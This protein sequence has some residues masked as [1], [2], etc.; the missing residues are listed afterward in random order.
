MDGDVASLHLQHL[1]AAPSV[2]LGSGAGY[3]SGL[4]SQLLHTAPSA[5]LGTV[6]GCLVAIHVASSVQPRS[7]S[8]LVCAAP[9]LQLGSAADYVSG[10][11]S[12]LLHTTYSNL[13]TSINMYTP[14]DHM[15]E[16]VYIF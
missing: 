13:P 10:L 5:Q 2:Q 8:A 15:G 1:H 4:H 7:W 3:V 9:S 16:E 14:L 11:H 12:H 6:D